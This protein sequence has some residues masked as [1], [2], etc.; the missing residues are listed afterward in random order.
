MLSPSLMFFWLFVAFH[1]ANAFN[2]AASYEAIYFY[3]AYKTEY[4]TTIGNP[5]LR[6]IAPDVFIDLRQLLR[7]HPQ[8]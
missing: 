3:N 2:A 7:Q 8:E 5:A 4:A 1:V 6:T